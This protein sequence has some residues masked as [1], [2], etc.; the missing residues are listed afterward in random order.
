MPDNNTVD[1]R[2]LY[3]YKTESRSCWIC[4]LIILIAKVLRKVNDE[5]IERKF[6]MLIQSNKNPIRT[7]ALPITICLSILFMSMVPFAVADSKTD[8]NEAKSAPTPP[9]EASSAELNRIKALEGKWKSTTSMFGK[10]NEEVFTEYK[11][12]AGGS[13]VVETIFPGTPQEMI[14]VYYDDDQGKLAM[15]HYCV[16]R[17]RPHF[18]L[19]ESTKDKLKMDVTEVAGLK[20][21]DA[22]SMGAITLKFKDEDHFSSTCE[23]RGKAAE[24]QDPITMHYARVIE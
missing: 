9:P 21:K 17:N 7:K 22:P 6:C 8:R 11:I 19:I 12:T 13:A 18:S 10:E 20:S 15:T 1:R 14:S 3:G 16:M 24:T 23:S 4:D 5:F 2:P